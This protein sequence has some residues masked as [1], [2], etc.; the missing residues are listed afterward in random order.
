MLQMRPSRNH[1]RQLDEHIKS[2]KSD[3][4]LK[5]ALAVFISSSP[6]VLR[7]CQH[8][9]TAVM[10]CSDGN[11][12]YHTASLLLDSNRD[13]VLSEAVEHKVCGADDIKVVLHHLH[14]PST[15]HQRVILDDS[16]HRVTFGSRGSP[17]IALTC[18]DY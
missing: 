8:C 7:C 11:L 4:A 17:G 3:C 9:L 13:V 5:L 16:L 2:I 12:R 18:S 15:S 10:R 6:L 1:T 14:I